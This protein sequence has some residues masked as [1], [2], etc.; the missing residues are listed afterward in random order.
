M[1]ELAVPC[2]VSVIGFDPAGMIFIHPKVQKPINSRSL[3]MANRNRVSAII[4]TL[5]GLCPHRPTHVVG[6]TVRRQVGRSS[7]DWASEPT[8]YRSLPFTEAYLSRSLPLQKPPP[9][10]AS[11]RTCFSKNPRLLEQNLLLEQNARPRRCHIG[12]WRWSRLDGASLDY[13]K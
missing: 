13:I 3:T 9:T 6:S 2:V 8:P 12:I 4:E 10:Q 7:S 5:W 11:L 1:R